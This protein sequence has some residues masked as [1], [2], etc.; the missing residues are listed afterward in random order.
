MYE[1]TMACFVYFRAV[2]YRYTNL[3]DRHVYIHNECCLKVF[4]RDVAL[5]EL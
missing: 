4:M 3:M 1:I 5:G 2:L